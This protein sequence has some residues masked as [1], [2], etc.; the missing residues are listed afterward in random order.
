MK[1]IITGGGQ[2]EKAVWSQEWK[3]YEQAIAIS[4]DWETG[5]VDRIIE[6]TSPPDVISEKGANNVFKA[7]SLIKNKLYLCTQTEVMIYS[8]PELELIRYISLPCFNDLHHV[9]VIDN[10]I[11]VVSTGLDMLVLI[12]RDNK[13]IKYFNAL[14]L[15]PW[16]KF[17]EKIDYRKVITTKPH[18]SH[19]NYIFHIEDEIWLS[20]FEQK[21][22]IC[23]TD[24]NKR[25]N[26]GVERI[27]DGIVKNNNVYF[28]TVNGTVCVAN[29]KTCKVEQIFDLN[30]VYNTDNPLG[31]CR[32][33]HVQNDRLYIGFS[34]LRSTR[35]RENLA[36][37]KA[38]FR[39]SKQTMRALPTRIVEFDIKTRKIIKEVTL[40]GI[41]LDAIFSILKI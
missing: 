41:G 13:A 30:E 21:D 3:H 17:S 37:I 12:D 23:I 8:F 10:T 6:Y 5:K 22:A 39:Q 35:L 25:I 32:G 14:G 27:H 34:S 7:G 26:I 19:P 29:P 1:F 40:S 18:E 2:K 31:W 4:L 33:L 11:A 38:G 16:G 24:P 15:D 20:R 28:T 36:W 9:T